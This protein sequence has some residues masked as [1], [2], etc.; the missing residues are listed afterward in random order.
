MIKV[1]DNSIN[2]FFE[3]GKSEIL[4]LKLGFWARLFGKQKLQFN[5]KD[6]EKQTEIKQKEVQEK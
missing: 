3:S 5:Y 6:F 1:E 4:E 2:V